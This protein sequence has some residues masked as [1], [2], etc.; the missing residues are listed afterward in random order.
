MEFTLEDIS[1]DEIA[2]RRDLYEPLTDSVRELVDA[3]IRTE[4]DD[5]SVR[6]AHRLIEAAVNTLRAKQIDGSYGVRFTADLQGMPWGNAVIGLRNAI[7]P[8]VQTVRHADDRVTADFTLGA[9]YEGPSDCVHGGICAMVLDHVL[10]EAGSAD[11]VPC[12]TGTISLRFLRPTPLGSLHAE[13][14]IVERDGRKKIVHGSLSDEK[15]QTVTAEG[16]F[17]VPKNWDGP[18]PRKARRPGDA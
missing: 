13:A 14:V 10:G 9:A 4:V 8:P 6:E 17:I 11:D 15:G 5:D 7:A 3:V 16:V 2:R 1:D 18:M 12:Y